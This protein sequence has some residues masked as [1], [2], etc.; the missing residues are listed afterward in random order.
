MQTC[1]VDGMCETACPVQINT[2]DLVRRLR[3]E[4]QAGWPTGLG[5]G[6]PAVGRSHPRGAARR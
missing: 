1:A 3:R 2:G 4:E 6:G 5:T